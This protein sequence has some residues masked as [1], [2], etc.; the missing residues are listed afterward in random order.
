MEGKRKPGAQRISTEDA[1]LIF[2]KWHSEGTLIECLG[3]F[4]GW[5]LALKGK[6]LAV[7]REEVS[8]GE[9]NESVITFRLDGDDLTFLYG[10]AKDAPIDVSEENKESSAL[11]LGLPFRVTVA[12][13][14]AA[15]RGEVTEA[16][17]RE[18]LCFLEL[19]R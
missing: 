8:F 3:R 17:S 4:F 6:V 1:F 9:K 2:D 15:Q 14:L 5:G 12:T 10:E 11:L 7:S 18:T 19:L 13:A 16:P